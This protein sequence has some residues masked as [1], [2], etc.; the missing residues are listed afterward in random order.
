MEQDERKKVT[1]TRKKDVNVKKKSTSSNMKKNDVQRTK[2]TDENI[3][4]SIDKKKVP[5]KRKKYNIVVAIIC[6]IL[7][8]LAGVVGGLYLAN[9]F[10]IFSKKAVDNKEETVE[11][12]SENQVE[13]SGGDFVV[14][15][16]YCDLYFP[17]EWADQVE[18][19]QE[20]GDVHAVS[21]YGMVDG[22]ERKL[23]FDVLFG[24]EVGSEIGTLN[25]DGQDIRVAIQFANINV[26]ETWTEDETNTIYS[27]QEDVN[28]LMDELKNMENFTPIE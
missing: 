14:E 19:E 12:D 8:I 2:V 21:F 4:K 25:V 22:K 27:M 18:V 7:G 17:E 15:T 9:N 13:E 26:D 16:P 20:E 5:T 24:E 1:H 10:E 11:V 23:L 6:L 28:Y 3:A